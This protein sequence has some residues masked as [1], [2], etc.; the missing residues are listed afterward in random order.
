M[1]T[2]DINEMNEVYMEVSFGHWVPCEDV[3]MEEPSINNSYD[4]GSDYDPDADSDYEKEISSPKK[5]ISK[6]GGFIIFA[7]HNKIPG[8]TRVAMSHSPNTIPPGCNSSYLS[9]RVSDK[10]RSRQNICKVLSKYR[11]GAKS[12]M[13]QGEPDELIG[14]VNRAKVKMN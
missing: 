5:T 14:M 7:T 9:I 13:F 6:R 11:F 10:K 2:I 12:N 8:V 1:R 4:T 3:V